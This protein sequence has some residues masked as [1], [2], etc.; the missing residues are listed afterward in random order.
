MSLRIKPPTEPPPM[1]RLSV[2]IPEPTA[3]LLSAYQKAYEHSYQ[4]PADGGFLIN[5]IL[6]SFFNADREFQ[7]FLKK[8]PEALVPEPKPSGNFQKAGVQEQER[9][10]SGKEAAA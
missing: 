9:H 1:T 10:Q 4:K 5:E 3:S 8:N 7:E 2:K 6:L